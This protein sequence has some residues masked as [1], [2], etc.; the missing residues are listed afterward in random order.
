[1]KSYE[2]GRRIWALVLCAAM[3]VQL[4][5]VQAHAEQTQSVLQKTATGLDTSVCADAYSCGYAD[6]WVPMFPTGTADNS[7][8]WPEWSESN[9]A[10]LVQTGHY[11]T[12]AL[13]IK[14]QSGRNTA[15]AIDV[16]MTPGKSYTL[17]LWARGTAQSQTLFSY[18]NGDFP[19]I[20]TADELSHSWQ[21]YE[22]S[23]TATVSQFNLGCRDWGD[24]SVWVDNITITDENG[25]DLL[26]GRGDFYTE[27]EAEAVAMSINTALMTG[28]H[29]CLYEDKWVPMFPTGAPDDS[30]TWPAW[31][32]GYNYAEIVSDGHQDIGALHIVSSQGRNTGVAINAGMT[33]G[34][35][36]TLGLWAR[37]TAQ[38]QSLFSYGN[39]NMAIVETADD[40]SDSWQ[41]Y[42]ISFTATMSQ[43]N[44]CCRDWNS[45]DVYVD[46]ITLTDASGCDLLA[47]LGD[48]WCIPD[49]TQFDANLDFE[50]TSG[51]ALALWEHTAVLASGSM[52]VCTEQVYSGEQSMRIE[53][54]K[55]RL[56]ASIVTSQ[57]RIPV[58]PGD[59][60]ELVAHLAS[61]QC[62]SG[63]F[64][65]FIYCYDANGEYLQTQHGQER[66]TCSDEAYSAWD[67]YELVCT[68]GSGV[69]YI[70]VGMRIGGT[71]ADVLVDDVQYY[72]YTQNGNTV[73]QE[74]FQAPSAVTGLPGGWYCRQEA[75][76]YFDGA[77]VLTGSG[78]YYTDLY[79]FTTDSTYTVT[80]PA[81]LSG[82]A[83]A[84]LV[85]QAIDYRGQDVGQTVIELENGTVSESFA[86][87]S[88]VYYRLWV[89]KTGSGT[90]S[91]DSITVQ[92]TGTQERSTES[93]FSSVR[94][95]FPTATQTAG[96]TVPVTG[97]LTLSQAP[98][99]A[100]YLYVSFCLSGSAVCTG[101]LVLS[102]GTTADWPVGSSFTADFQLPIPAILEAGTY[103]VRLQS[104]G[105]TIGL[106][107]VAAAA[108]E[109]TT[110]SSVETVDGKAVLT[111]NGEAQV[112]LWYARPENPE[113]FDAQTVTSFAEAGIDTVVSYVFLNNAYGDVWTA[114]GFVSDAVDEMM[115]A[116]LSGNP[117][118]KLIVAIDVNAPDWWLAENPDELVALSGGTPEGTGASFA[119][120]KW[121]QEAGE[122]MLQ[123][124]S[125]MLGRPYANNIIG[126]KITGGYTLEWNWW[127][128]SGVYD[129]VGDFSACGIA[130]FRAYLTEKYGTD[131]ALQAAYGD[132]TATLGTVLPPSAQARSDDYLDSVITVQDHPDMLDY[133]LFMAQL[134]AETIEYFAKLLKDATDDRLA[135]G[136]YAG[137]FYMGG[138]YE[139][140]S[141]VSNV[142]FQT[143]LE[144]ECIDFIK[145]P[146]MY[147]LRE[148]GDSAEVMGPS[149]SA[150]LHGKL[151][152]VEEDSR[153]NLGTMTEAQDD[154]AAVGWTRSYKQSVEQ[155]KRNFSYALTKGLGMSFYNLVWNFTDDAQYYGIIGQMVDEMTLT[156]SWAQQ[157]TA[158]IAVFVD[159]ESNMLI[160]FEDEAANT[161]LYN[162]V[163]TQQLRQL[164]HVGAPYDMYLLDDL[165]DGLVPAHKINIFLGTT[166]MTDRERAAV[167]ALQQD[168][169]ILIWVFTSGISDGRT[170]DLALLEEL[171]GMDLSII[172]TERR[173]VGVAEITDTTHWLTDGLPDGTCYGTQ[174]YSKLSPVIAVT[175][176]EATV[177]ASHV[178]GDDGIGGEGALAV[179][180]MGSYVSIYSAVPA[181]PQS[182]LRNVLSYAGCHSYTA[183][184]SDVVYASSGY[185][186]LHSIFAGEK[187]VYV[188]RGYEV[189]D[190]FTGQA[191][192][193]IGGAFTVTFTG[194][195]TRLYRLSPAGQVCTSVDAALR[196]DAYGAT[197]KQWLPMYPTGSPDD[198]TWCS[199][200]AQTNY[201]AVVSEGCG[202][203]GSLYMRS[204]PY[205][206]TGIAI[207]AGMT[208]GK[209][210][211]LGLWA[212][213]TSDSG[214][215]LGL[216]ANSD[217]A[218]IGTSDRLQEE[219][220]Y[221]EVSFT[222]TV[223][224]L[225][226]V[227][228]DWGTTELWLDNITL[229]DESGNDLLAG[230]GDFWRYK[231]DGEEDPALESAALVL[232]GVL[233]LRVAAT[234][235]ST[236][237]AELGGQTLRYLSY[238]GVYTLL[239]PA[240]R[241]QE[242]VMLRL[243]DGE[244]VIDTQVWTLEQYLAALR[245]EYADDASLL[246]LAEA[247]E[248]YAAYAAYYADP[249]GEAPAS[250]QVGAVTAGDLEAYAHEVTVKDARQ[251]KPAVSVY[252][253]DACDLLVK[254][255]ADAFDGCT[256]YIGG[257]A[258]ET[259]ESDG[260]AVGSL[261]RL[262]PQQWCEQYDISVVCDGSCVYRCSY[263]VLSY[264][265]L[266]LSYDGQ[267]PE[268]AAD[269][270]RAMY[271]YSLAC[272]AYLQRSTEA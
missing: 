194:K 96:T 133:E 8:T 255:S 165:A 198:Y 20:S 145:S 22:V 26:S 189:C 236:M 271:L 97:T 116:T 208:V 41:Y 171:C 94:F 21:Y 237:L 6:V 126:F 89:V 204:S 10:E 202:D 68:I 187:T 193:C 54:S 53:R 272:S 33:A 211:T 115:Y 120:D 61:R 197:E 263:S 5:P 158:D 98:E 240:H 161:M 152:I 48:F 180:D 85:L 73:Y 159:G 90:A 57:E 1:M 209:V 31:S 239:V 157:S 43:L 92:K 199:W 178:A 74:D 238:G 153:L 83:G 104:S 184:G 151:W 75:S 30:T 139:F 59:S 86:A 101:K 64:S 60:I 9:Y 245:Q 138:G 125:Y 100:Q 11:E 154:R 114:D 144:S 137:Y 155:L 246:A 262:L 256:L 200:D 258:V 47:G 261:S 107:K 103:T 132:S 192:E 203:V 63:Y 191:V 88:A 249:T 56:D 13:Y 264:V 39:G 150:A 124:V 110:T 176:A 230:Y 160:P 210:Y 82:E 241:L 12:G 16:G 17:G 32:S 269:L 248:D 91:I 113:L 205:K 36:Y 170:T 195:E 254:F 4:L 40:L 173:F 233:Q 146:W 23:F 45:N 185:V 265:R 217:A 225:S 212:K 19:I 162:S 142:Y 207:Q 186:A 49:E 134:K 221:Y 131:E 34:E 108:Q 102:E 229:T 164:G 251:L 109:L 218:V 42:E 140:T 70:A 35:T 25:V 226:L 93:V 105:A 29:A 141:A 55:G 52:S 2:K 257:T 266:L 183:S 232:G 168:G 228:S 80:V 252:L 58:A 27:V 166:L 214:R 244:S 223:S 224:Q 79:C 242:Q 106:V 253:D 121:K 72:N 76:G 143:L 111:V 99:E 213:G 87:V 15:V 219:W 81:L 71:Y 156:L 149:D 231:A 51:G 7:T 14:S 188:P 119:S 84:Q 135:V 169:N 260:L 69:Y 179:K 112:P 46:N 175:D 24:N 62:V 147:G 78:S 270:T 206:N 50:N 250:E 118:A 267:L 234:G 220:T 201:A 181:L 167:E 196:T 235:G 136:T 190:V 129:D 38:S 268:G 67:T 243:C 65:M 95:S 77:M 37:G 3:A 18:A 117:E 259:T 163:Y 216:Y 148:I 122:V 215:V 227:A 28:A 247:L 44:L 66:S 222:A 182:L 172:S 174:S 127:G 128:T 123:A 130:A 177:L